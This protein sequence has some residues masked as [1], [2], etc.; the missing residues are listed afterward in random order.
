M[1][2]TDCF[3][4]TVKFEKNYDLFNLKFSCIKEK[5]IFA[6][7]VAVTACTANYRPDP[8]DLLNASIGALTQDESLAPGESYSGKYGISSV[9][10][11]SFA[12]C[13]AM[14]HVRAHALLQAIVV[15][16]RLHLH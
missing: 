5:Q 9:E 2:F 11:L 13:P 4:A 16:Q 10:Q 8:F 12:V 7:A 14:N 15:E 6:D 3:T 1:D